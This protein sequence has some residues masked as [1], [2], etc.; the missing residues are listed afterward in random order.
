MCKV[1]EENPQES[2]PTSSVNQLVGSVN[3]SKNVL[4]LETICEEI[5]RILSPGQAN[6]SPSEQIILNSEQHSQAEQIN[7]SGTRSPSAHQDDSNPTSM[8]KSEMMDMVSESKPQSESSK[9]RE[10][11]PDP[12]KEK[13]ESSL[14]V[15]APTDPSPPRVEGTSLPDVTGDDVMDERKDGAASNGSNEKSESGVIVLDD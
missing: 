8:V 6:P 10:S 13:S 15:Q 2:V 12:A 5:N 14:N 1:M 4:S 9:L 3:L 11:D 7:V